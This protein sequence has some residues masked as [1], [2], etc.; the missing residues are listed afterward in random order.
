MGST[1]RPGNHALIFGATG[2]QGWA[3]TH[4]LLE[5]YPSQDSFE[6]VTALANRKPTEAMLWPESEKLQVVSGINLLNDNGQTALESQLQEQ[7]PGIET[8]THVF[9]FGAYVSQASA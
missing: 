4:A 8:V 2:I 5:G 1:G 3:V 9:F 6:R 7:V